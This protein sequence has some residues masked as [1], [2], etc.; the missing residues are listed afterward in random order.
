MGSVGG[1]MTRIQ[2]VES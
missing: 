1:W 2:R